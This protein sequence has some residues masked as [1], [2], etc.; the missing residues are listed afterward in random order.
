MADRA[1]RR[2]SASLAVLH[3]TWAAVILALSTTFS[4]PV[5]GASWK[6]NP[7]AGSRSRTCSSTS[8]SAR[9]SP[10]SCFSQRSTTLSSLPP[11][12]ARY[13]RCLAAGINP[14]RWLE[15]SLRPA[16]VLRL[17]GDDGSDRRL[18]ERVRERACE[19]VDGFPAGAVRRQD[20]A[21]SCGDESIDC[22]LDD[23]FEDAA[24]EV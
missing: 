6:A 12:R 13:E 18:H 21:H 7:G 20:S 16:D 9:S 3:A 8:A 5:T 19:L 22:R 4:L 1:L 11:C 10:L 15:Y 24:R 23:R 14:F 2:G 17:E